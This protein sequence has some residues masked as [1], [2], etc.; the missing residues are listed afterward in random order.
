MVNDEDVEGLNSAH[1][2]RRG[3]LLIQADKTVPQSV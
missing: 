1:V 2:A 3:A